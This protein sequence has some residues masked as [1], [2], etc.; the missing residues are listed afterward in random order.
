[1]AASRKSFGDT[2]KDS[3]GCG[4]AVTPGSDCGRACGR[5]LGGSRYDPAASS[6]PAE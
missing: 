6:N 5:A 2:D 1:V 4:G 3:V